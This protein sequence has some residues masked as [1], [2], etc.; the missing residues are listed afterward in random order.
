MTALFQGAVIQICS[1]L[2]FQENLS[3][4]QKLISQAKDGGAEN[5]FLPEV[6]YSMSD[7]IEPTPYLLSP[8]N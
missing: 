3:K 2:D 1:K 7:G 6:F 4:I 5:I 8:G